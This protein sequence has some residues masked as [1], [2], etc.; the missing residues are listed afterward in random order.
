MNAQRFGNQASRR[1]A[2]MS[3]DSLDVCY[4]CDKPIETGDDRVVGD[5][6]AA[7]RRC[8]HKKLDKLSPHWRREIHGAS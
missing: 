4:I 3:F 2:A 6:T 5:K 8:V 7:H 1:R